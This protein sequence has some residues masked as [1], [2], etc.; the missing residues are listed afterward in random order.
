MKKRRRSTATMFERFGIGHAAVYEAKDEAKEEGKEAVEDSARLALE[1]TSEEEGVNG[2]GQKGDGVETAP[3]PNSSEEEGESENEGGAAAAAGALPAAPEKEGLLAEDA[4]AAGAG[5]NEAAA[6]PPQPEVT[7][8]RRDGD[9]GS[10]Y[11][12]VFNRSS[13]KE[14]DNL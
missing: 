2:V 3:E 13:E 4:T 12:S 6:V 14:E 10:F 1:G 8:S 9:G 5:E 11:D 7:L